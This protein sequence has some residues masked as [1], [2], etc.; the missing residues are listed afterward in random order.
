[1]QTSQ[2][3]KSYQLTKKYG[4]SYFIATLLMGKQDRQH[5]YALYSLCRYADDLVDVADGKPGTND[6]AKADLAD[7]KSKVYE[8]IENGSSDPNLLGAI[9]KTYNELELDIELLDKFF[10]SMEMDLDITSYD[11]HQDLERYTDGSAAVIG[12]MV[13]PILEK[14]S[15]KH[16]SLRPF[17]RDLGFAFQLTNFLRDVGE[18]LQRGRI[19][20][21]LKSFADHGVDP[22]DIKYNTAFKEMMK[23]EIEYTRKIYRRS[24]EGVVQLRGRRGACVRC[25]YRLYGG[26]LDE[27]ERANYDVLNDR[28]FVPKVKKYQI[29]LR[30]L[31]R[32]NP[33]FEKR[34]VL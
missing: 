6:S 18:D 5:V 11:T 31:T 27:I 4:T 23:S 33:H 17:A 21:P 26:I 14:D 32:F 9:A 19:Y 7:F 10:K 30:E 1:M 15:N 12:E 2:Y 25:A 20:I 29:A 28:V 16:E 34:S 24:Y 3:S 13:L 22:K 8:A